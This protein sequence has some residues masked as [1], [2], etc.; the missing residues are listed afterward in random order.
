MAL[1]GMKLVF[2]ACRAYDNQTMSRHATHGNLPAWAALHLLTHS[3]VSTLHGSTSWALSTTFHG[4][5]NLVILTRVM[6]YHKRSER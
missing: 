2:D 1:R 6:R 4:W 5:A 3:W